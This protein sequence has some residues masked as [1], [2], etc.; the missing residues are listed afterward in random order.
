MKYTLK[1]KNPNYNGVTEGVPFAKGIG[2][3]EDENVRNVL[4]NNYKYED[5]TEYESL[6]DMSV[7]E[8]QAEAK[9]LGLTGYSKLDKDELLS[10]LKSADK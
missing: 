2:H 4:V 1:T 10:L 5:V 9:K 3:T 6:D 7:K 8:L